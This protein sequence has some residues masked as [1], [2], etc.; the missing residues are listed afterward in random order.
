MKK[1]AMKMKKTFH[2]FEIVSLL[3]FAGYLVVPATP[4]LAQERGQPVP[5]SGAKPLTRVR[6]ALANPIIN[7]GLSFVWICSH[8][9]WYQR[10]GIVLE[11]IRTQ[12]PAD[13]T[14]RVAAGQ[15]EF[16]LPPPAFYVASAASGQDLGL[17]SVYLLRRQQQ[18]SFAVLQ[19]SPIKALKDLK[20]KK[21]GVS[22]LGD[23]GVTYVKATRRELKLVDSELQMVPV[24]A[25][26]AATSSLQTGVV[27]VLALP[28][29]QYALVEGLGVKL[30]HLPQPAFAERVFGNEIVT[31]RD[32]VAKS[33]EVV[34]GL[35]KGFAMGSA[36]F[37]ANP[38]AAIEISF[39]MFP[40]TVPKGM[41]LEEAV[42]GQVAALPPNIAT[43]R[44]DNKP[45]KKWGCNSEE[46]WKA[47]I[48]Y[49]GLDLS[50]TGDVKRFFTNEFIDYANSF[51]QKAIQDLARNFVL[52]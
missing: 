50:K 48:E 43:L 3:L 51:D 35:L 8:F 40:E 36:F 10:E 20:G 2:A 47:Y 12:G 32:Y 27:D 28:G 13:A 19:D 16:G 29:V 25:A 1:S 6:F 34:K 38:K 17:V 5:A 11:I 22:S 4:L 42:A 30:R 18:Y 41:S 31:R 21:V 24:G 49:L 14:Q 37:V 9:G 23:E 26:G 39:K 7:P 44:F 45:C 52:K 46:D 15:V 33:P